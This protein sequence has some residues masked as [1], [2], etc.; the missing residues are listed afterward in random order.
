MKEEKKAEPETV[1]LEIVKED[2]PVQG[3]DCADGA[4]L[5]EKAVCKVKGVVGA[6]AGLPGPGG[7]GLG[8]PLDGRLR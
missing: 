8:H 2:F 5:L 3:L 4:Q 7:R 1:G 6:Q